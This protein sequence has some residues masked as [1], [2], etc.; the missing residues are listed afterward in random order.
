MVKKTK[1]GLE[2]ARKI[3]EA[4]LKYAASKKAKPSLVS[5]LWPGTPCSFA[6]VDHAGILIYFAR[7]DGAVPLTARMAVN[8]AYTAI[9][10]GRDT[11][12]EAKVLKEVGRSI[13]DFCD[14]RLTS[15][16]GGVLIKSSDGSVL[17]AVG[18]SG[19]LAEEDEEL[20]RVGAGAL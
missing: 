16:P 15:I 10:T 2:E 19:R 5:S 17:G 14:P 12:D 6:V 7:M 8:K 18:V 4:M 13:R 1:L 3:I 11:V 20:A 9:D